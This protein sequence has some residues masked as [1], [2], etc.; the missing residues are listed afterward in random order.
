[1]GTK[2]I[3]YRSFKFLLPTLLCAVG[4]HQVQAQPK[5][6]DITRGLLVHVANQCGKYKIDGT[7]NCLTPEFYKCQDDWAKCT[8]SCKSENQACQEFCDSKYS[9]QCGD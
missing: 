9:A 4:G 2:M 1:M 6:L 7:G 3:V 8:K 5:S